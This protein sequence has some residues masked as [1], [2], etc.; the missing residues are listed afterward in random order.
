MFSS[1]REESASSEDSRREEDVFVDRDGRAW[2]GR[3]G[4]GLSG[5]GTSPCA[6]ARRHGPELGPG[7]P[8]GLPGSPL[9]FA[10]LSAAGKVCRV[11]DHRRQSVFSCYVFILKQLEIY[12]GGRKDNTEA[13]RASP[14]GGVFEAAPSR[15]TRGVRSSPFATA[16]CPS[17]QGTAACLPFHTRPIW[18]FQLV[19]IPKKAAM[20]IHVQVSCE[21]QFS[22]IWDKSP[23]A[24]L[25]DHMVSV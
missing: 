8:R 17:V 11:G 10:G 18:G 15:P 22:F 21:P 7:P 20:N 24:Q 4:K 3:E 1:V 12:T 14:D 16:Q 2:Q 19:P 13:R 5:R 6:G 23:G 25:L 9:T